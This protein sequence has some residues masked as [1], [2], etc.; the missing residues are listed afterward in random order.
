MK[1]ISIGRDFKNDVII[2][3]S[4]VSSK[5]ITITIDEEGIYWV[6]DLNSKNGVFIN[7]VK[8]QDTKINPGDTLTIGNTNLKWEEYFRVVPDSLAAMRKIVKKV[9]LGRSAAND[10][11]VDSD[12]VSS[13]H[14]ILYQTDNNEC[15]LIDLNSTNGSFVN[16]QRAM[17]CKLKAGDYLTLANYPIEW[18]KILDVNKNIVPVINDLP[19]KKHKYTP[20]QIAIFAMI[21]FVVGGG[22]A[23]FVLPSLFSETKTKKDLSQLAELTEKSV[24]LIESYGSDGKLISKGSGFFIDKTGMGM[25]NLHVLDE[26]TKFVIYT[27]DNKS[28]NINNFLLKNVKNDFV[29]FSIEAPEGK[30]FDALKFS[31]ELPKKGEDIFVI[32]NPKGIESTLSKGIVSSLRAVDYSDSTIS[33]GNSHLQLDV[34]ISS[35]SSGGPVFNMDGEVIGM[36]TL[37]IMECDNCN[38]AI[39]I[40]VIEDFLKE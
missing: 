39:S 31:K 16:G 27:F 32:G 6:K 7:G 2:E 29:I 36:V 19:N 33:E 35:G 25:S 34:A 18:G 37:K 26:G 40:L 15:W 20:I 5:H 3:D 21:V 23:F 11:P 14:A 9:M 28:Y 38:F 12:L 1:T 10:I 17:I 4:F 13:E 30:E 22:L 8:V 24:F